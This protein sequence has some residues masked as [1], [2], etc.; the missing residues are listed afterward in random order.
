MGERTFLLR[1]GF[2][3]CGK[4]TKIILAAPPAS[5]RRGKQEMIQLTRYCEHCNRPNIINVPRSWD[6][7]PSRLVYGEDKWIVGSRDDMAIIQGEKP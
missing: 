4:E 7:N 1:C 5:R 3:D 6:S 2:S